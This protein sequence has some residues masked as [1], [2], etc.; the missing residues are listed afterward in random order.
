MLLWMATAAAGTV[1]AWGYTEGDWGDPETALIDNNDWENGYGEDQWYVT[2]AG[3]A[4][5]LTDDNVNDQGFEEYGDGEAQDNWVINGV[6]IEDVFIEGSLFNY[7]NDTVGLVSHHDGDGT[8]YLLFHSA[9]SAPP[10]VEVVNGGTLVL[11]RIED[12][13]PEIL[14]EASAD[15]TTGEVHDVEWSINDGEIT[16]AI[17]GRDLIEVTD[18]SPLPAGLQGLYAYDSGWDEQTYCGAT[19]LVVSFQDDDDD[20]VPD[21]QDNCELLENPGQEDADGDGLGDACDEGPGGD[22]TG[23][24]GASGGVILTP[25]GPCGCASG[26]QTGASLA[27]LVL[28]GLLAR[29]RG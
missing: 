7:D 6:A 15:L 24:T 2:Q 8:F 29:R 23:D 28:L 18:D 25:S 22:D 17:N 21:D 3:N 10:P 19:D 26:S 12:G 4:A 14:A 16:V 1:E 13:Q 9:D 27:A 5:S 20:G 11:V